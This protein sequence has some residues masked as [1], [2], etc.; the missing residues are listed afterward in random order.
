MSSPLL[1]IGFHKTG[2]TLL[3]TKLFNRRDLGF[4]RLDNDRD[5]LH[6][7]FIQ[8][9]PFRAPSDSLI[10]GLREEVDKATDTGVRLVI[11]HERL[12]GY[13]ATGGFDAEVIAERLK[14]MFPGAKILI[15][16]REQSAIIKSF[17]LQY[18]SD[19]GSQSFRRLLRNPQP[20]LHRSPGFDLSFFEFDHAVRF[21]YELFGKDN[22]LVLPYES[23][24]AEPTDVASEIIRF[25]GDPKASEKIDASI[26][27]EKV[28]P[29]A[30][31]LMQYVRRT[32]NSALTRTQLSNYGLINIPHFNQLFRRLRPV[33]EPFR[34]LDPY[35][36]GRLT[37]DVHKAVEGRFEESN[38][39]LAMSTGL[40]LRALGYR[41]P[42]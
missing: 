28:N 34:F 26:F 38:D 41:L 18:I 37:R 1:H 32:C 30:P 6:R 21:Y 35:L 40:D 11:S 42:D 4:M 10:S 20:S 7:E 25:A 3:Q 5:R 23:I 15:M 9:A 16:V 39:R 33:F 2:S 12:S 8:Y 22:V 17:Y 29:A 14:Y 31:L 36:A 27:G 19:G 13:P 24:L